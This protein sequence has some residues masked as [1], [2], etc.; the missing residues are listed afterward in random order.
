MHWDIARELEAVG[1]SDQDAFDLWRQSFNYE[2]PHQALGMRCP[3]ELYRA[4]ERKYEGTPED[5]D[6]PQMCSRRVSP[7]GLISLEG[8]KLF[9]SAS[10]G[11]WSVGLKPMAEDRMEVWFGRLF[12]G[13]V[14][15]AASSFI[16]A[17]LR[18][19]KTQKNG[20]DP[21]E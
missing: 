15:L 18:S 21:P 17:D 2:R 6:Y 3:G 20:G 11:G 5:L 7:T 9:L 1:E 10:L 19:N 12:L 8:Q 14:D 13:E 16:R 4:S